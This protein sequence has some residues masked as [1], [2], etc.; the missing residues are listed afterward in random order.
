MNAPL[1]TAKRLLLVGVEA[2]DWNLIHPLMDEALLPHW[3]QMVESGA[4]GRLLCTAP[5]IPA[6]QWASLATGKRPWQ[7]GVCH[8]R[9]IA[10][11]GRNS[12][13]VT[14]ASRRSPALWEILV[15]Q[16]KRCVTVGWP[17]THGEKIQ[18]VTVVSD[19]YPAPTAGPG[20]TPWPPPPAGTYWPENLGVTLDSLR[21]SPETI[22]ADVISLYLPEWKKI[23]QRRDFRLGHLRTLVASDFSC[24]AAISELLKKSSWDF[25]AV[26]FP[27]LGNIAR[28]FLPYHPPRR[29]S[30]SEQDFSIY[31]DVMRSECRMLDLILQKLVQI[32]GPETA[33]VLV[34]DHGLRGFD[35]SP[36]GPPASDAE[37]W[38]SPYG[39]F[40]ASGPGFATDALLHGATV[41]DVAPTILTWFGIPIGDDMEGRVLVESFA[42]MPEIAR[43]PSW[44]S[45]R[46]AISDSR[47]QKSGADRIDQSHSDEWR[48]NFVLSCLE[49][50][51]LERAMPVLE[52]LFRSFPERTE[53][54]ETLFECQLELKRADD[55]SQ[56]LEILLEGLSPGPRSLALRAQL[57]WAQRD[58]KQARALVHE[59]VQLHCMDRPTLS[60]IGILLLRLREWDR[61]ELLARQG[62]AL[63]EQEPLAWLGLAAA[64]L[65]KR[66]PREAAEAARRAIS[67]KYFLPDAHLIL[68]RALIAEGNWAEARG[69]LRALEKIHPN[70]RA[71][72][73]FARKIPQDISDQHSA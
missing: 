59:A 53:V 19:A 7:H 43:V 71:A 56:T 17:G 42:S 28:L 47:E 1:P 46:S 57:A 58:F 69:A 35:V 23:D 4:S 49:A 62:I 61:L 37:N 5:M 3:N 40:A 32:A 45:I 72:A 48:W 73:N 41:M 15:N 65:Q 22:Q 36:Q 52:E 38:K 18:G 54:A 2:A 70:T 31:K 44:D 66:Q 27:A 12:R 6:A 11:D 64:L 13:P 25:A 30:V 29:A 68:V 8:S 34:S 21:V 33:I 60:R 16:G 51:Q 26:R 50:G 24:L 10:D 14:A 67:L 63:D 9:E 55:A 20:V 39:I